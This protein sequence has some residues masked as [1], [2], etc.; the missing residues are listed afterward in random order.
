MR[1][2]VT[3][4]PRVARFACA[5]CG[6]DDS[7]AGERAGVRED[8]A[9]P[10]HAACCAMADVERL[11]LSMVSILLLAAVACGGDDS[12]DPGADAGER[13]A[14]A[15]AGGADAGDADAGDAAACVAAGEAPAFARSE[16]NP[17]LLPGTRFEDGLLDI[18]ISDP[19][20]RWDEGNDVWRA[21]WMGGHADSYVDDDM[22]QVI[23]S[24][25][26]A[27]GTS[28]TVRDQPILAA[29]SEAGAWDRVNTETPSVAVNPDAPPERRHLLLYSGASE[30][31]GQHAFPAYAIGAAFSA[32]G[33][34]FTRVPAD[35]SP[36]GQAGLVLTAEDVFGT[37]GVVAD[38]EV[39]WHDGLYH[40]WFSSFSCEGDGCLTVLAFG[41]SHATSPDGI[42]WTP[43]E[44]SPLP[45]LQRI[46]GER[47]A[48]GQQ[49]SVVRDAEHCR[50]EMWLTN[51]REEDVAAQPVDFNNAGGFYRAVSEDGI[52]WTVDYEQPRDLVW[53]EEAPGEALGLLTGADVA[54]RGDQRLMLYVGFDEQNVP[55][56]F[57]LPVRGEPDMVIP[58]VFALDVATR[59]Q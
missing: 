22:V 12:S 28:W 30:P 58:G 3:S 35:E 6:V 46:V 51:D 59:G 43:D 44:D 7:N 47:T 37:S 38:P 11:A 54:A 56:G 8:W 25:Q 55:P 50:W 31:L 41:I 1:R 32:D 27:D 40:M 33:V 29:S 48:G 45:S 39:V 21:T 17:A 10:R 19:D 5:G 15:D 53:D 52:E 34:T 14:G 36:H 23:R 49:P 24:A 13:D 20:V 42:A 9:G 57:L 26:S 2:I 18:S 16:Q 4:G